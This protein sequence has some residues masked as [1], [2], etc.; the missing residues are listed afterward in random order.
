LAAAIDALAER[1]GASRIWIVAHGPV[2]PAVAA[3]VSQFGRAV[4]LSIHDDPAWSDVFRTRRE[5]PLTPWVLRSLG[6]A[7]RAANSVDVI[8]A[9]MRAELARRYGVNSVIVHRVLEAPI[10]ANEVYDRA[11]GLSVGILGNLYAGRQLDLLLAAVSRASRSAGV[12]GRIVVIGREHPDLARRAAAVPDVDVTFA[13]HVPE[14]EGVDLLR[15]VFA[16]YLGYPFGSRSRVF[17]RTS[18]PTKLGTYLLS[19]R[20]IIVHTPYDSTLTPIVDV[21]PFTL[22]WFADTA[23]AGARMLLRAWHHDDLHRSQHEPAETLRK[24]YFGPE[25]RTTLFAALDRLPR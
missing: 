16:V 5:L 24:R 23:D 12:P 3:L 21:A 11:L 1:Q 20:P 25:N 13:G 18:F 15:R 7:L 8:S 4:H 6:V 22:P 10:P 14:S 2:L 17:R 9:G 19:A